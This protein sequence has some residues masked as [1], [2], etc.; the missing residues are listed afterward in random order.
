M[1]KKKRR[2]FSVHARVAVLMNSGNKCENCESND[3]LHIHHKDFDSMNNSRDNA[4]AV[5]RDCH[6][7]LHRVANEVKWEQ[8]VAEVSRKDLETEQKMK[9]AWVESGRS[10]DEIGGEESAKF[11]SNYLLR[12][13]NE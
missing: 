2:N 7:E 5:C 3:H 12:G 1:S 10:L 4:Q 13:N 11:F 9:D 8:H 6:T